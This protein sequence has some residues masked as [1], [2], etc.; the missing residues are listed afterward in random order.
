MDQVVSHFIGLL[1][2]GNIKEITTFYLTQTPQSQAHIMLFLN[3]QANKSVDSFDYFQRLSVTLNGERPM[4]TPLVSQLK[5]NQ[6]LSFFT[7]LLQKMA[8][9]SLQDTMKRNVLHYLFVARGEHTN[10]PFT[11]VRSLLLFES[12]VFLPKALSQRESNGLTPLECYLHLNIQG[13][14]LPNHE[15]TAFIALCEIERS[16]IT[17][18]SNNLNSAL[19]RFKKQR[20]DFDLTP[21]YIEQKCLLLASYYGVSEQHITTSLN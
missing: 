2:T 12:N 21:D 3:L 17:L 10:V 5:N 15:L 1:K 9:F 11:Y 13:T 6:A 18:N 16:Q 4:P 7:P 19:K 20:V 14:V 8:N